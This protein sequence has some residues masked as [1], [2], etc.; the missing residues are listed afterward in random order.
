MSDSVTY[1]E[2]A[3]SIVAG[4]G[5][6]IEGDPITVRPPGYSYILTVAMMLGLDSILAFKALNIVLGAAALLA[7]FY[8]MRG[9]IP[10]VEAM[11]LVLLTG[12]MFPWIYYSHTILSDIMFALVIALFLIVTMKYQAGEKLWTLI[13]LTI[14]TAMAPLVRYAGIALFPAWFYA[15]CLFD[16][17]AYRAVR[18]KNW[19][20]IVLFLALAC[21]V[22]IPVVG[23]LIRNLLLTGS[24]TAY[25]TGVNPE[26]AL[27]LKKLGITEFGLW[28][29]LWINARGYLHIFVIP[30]QV[31]IDR[32]SALPFAIRA[33]CVALWSL[34]LAGWIICVGKRRWRSVAIT[35]FSYFALLQFNTWYDIRY[36][37][38]VLPILLLFVIV[39]AGW[40][41]EKALAFLRVRN[42]T[43]R[44][45]IVRTTMIVALIVGISGNAAFALLSSKGKRLRRRGY[46]GQLQRLYEACQFI[47][48]EDRV[49]KVLVAGGGGFVPIWTGR[50]VV[51]C[52]E[53]LDAER[54]LQGYRLPDD[55]I[56]VLLDESGFV[57]YREEYLEPLV[58]ANESQLNEVFRRND[59]VVFAT[60]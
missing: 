49:G 19:R 28:T 6:V 18:A 46:D 42:V 41:L 47:R 52:L 11:L 38:P 24:I 7:F 53:L 31:G 58:N 51:S 21:V 34:V 16:S 30:D 45:A 10:T 35:F 32:T 29:K 59:T 43:R 25:T 54:K 44:A 12:V 14:I 15:V 56:F 3:K 60:R 55:V 40:I 36:L 23:F 8:S 20:R 17:R 22:V 57:P 37:L 4:D 48:N 27:S 33:G 26:Y 2:G 13:F 5:Y 9:I 39:A 1:I 50:N